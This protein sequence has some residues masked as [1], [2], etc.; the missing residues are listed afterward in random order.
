MNDAALV[1]IVGAE[2]VRHYGEDAVPHIREQAEIAAGLGDDLSLTAWT[3]IAE[4]VTML[5]SREAVVIF[6][7]EAKIA[8]GGS[9]A[10]RAAKLRAVDPT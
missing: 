5:M 7:A 8:A 2:M 6:A 10:P 4:A 9:G 1:V 3:D